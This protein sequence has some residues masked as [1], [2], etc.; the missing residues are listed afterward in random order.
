MNKKLRQILTEM[1]TKIYQFIELLLDILIT[2][3]DESLM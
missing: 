2:L 1:I 3:T